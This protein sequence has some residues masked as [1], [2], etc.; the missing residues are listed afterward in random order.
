MI[1]AGIDGGGTHTRAILLDGEGRVLA[2]GEAGPGNFGAIGIDQARENL[3]AALGQAWLYAELEPRPLDAL[4][5]GLAGVVSERDRETGRGLATALKLAPDTAIHI[6]HDIRIALAGSLAGEAGIHLIAGTGSS[7]YGRTS[8]G[9]SWMSGGWG[10]L[11]DDLGSSYFFGIEA[12]RALVQAHDGRGRMTALSGSTLEALGI[13]DV[14]QIMHRVYVE[15]LARHEV[16]ALAPLVTAAADAG[17]GIALGILDAGAEA[18]AAMVQGV[19]RRL[20]FGTSTLRISYSGGLIE[21]CPLYREKTIAAIEGLVPG[22]QIQTPRLAPLYGA[23]LLALEAAGVTL[24]EDI[25][26]GLIASQTK[27]DQGATQ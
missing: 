13:D 24:S 18:L 25:L 23:G 19:T 7:C 10:S 2:T 6:D 3:A 16:A 21:T 9:E 8:R 14:D 17:D 15:G 1:I 20:A 22:A 27:N 26:K 12:L 11:I 5:L 4:F